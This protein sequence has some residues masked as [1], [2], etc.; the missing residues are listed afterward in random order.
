MALSTVSA[1][2]A[3][4]AGKKFGGFAPKQTFS[5]KVEDRQAFEHKG[6][7][8]VVTFLIPAAIPKFN[9]GQTVK[10]TIGKKGQLQGPGFSLPLERDNK[11]YNQYLTSSTRKNPTPDTALLTKASSGKVQ[12]VAIYFYNKKVK[13]QSHSVTYVLK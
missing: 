4:P 10:F 3:G 11:G 13:G 2:A 7:E 9:V 8:T 1:Q 12:Q 6:Y 5:F